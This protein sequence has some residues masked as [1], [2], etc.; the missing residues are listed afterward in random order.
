MP[1]DPQL[2]AALTEAVGRQPDAVPLRLHLAG[3]LLESG[4]EEQA[5]SHY[6]AVL[7]LEPE[8]TDALLGATKAAE[9]LGDAKG[10]ALYRT[11]LNMA[12]PQEPV[13]ALGPEADKEGAV[14][15]APPG[16]AWWDLE[17]SSV[18]MSDVGGMGEVKRRLEVSFLGPMRNPDVRAAYGKALRGGLL[19]FGPPGCGKTFIARALAGELDARFI[20]VGLAD[21]LDMWLGESEKRVKELFRA[22]REHSPCVVFLDELDALGQKR[23]QLRHLGAQR[24]VVNQLLS[25]LDGISGGNEGV[26]VLAA[27]NHPWDVDTALLRPG[28]LDRMVLVLPPDRDARIVILTSKLAGRPVDHLDLNAIAERTGGFSGA[29]LTYLCDTATELAMEEAIQSGSIRQITQQHM[30][31]AL[32]EIRPSTREWFETARNFALFSNQGGV[33]DDLI[34]YMKEQKLM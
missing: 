16:H 31:R 21:I 24:G 30:Q 19:L 4:A 6:R 27:T 22:A 14:D 11:R 15:T 26:Y 17:V 32:K 28:R 18:R 10:A 33:Y 8:N 1:A 25:E 29:D 2:L 7:Q 20:A 9:A 23:T 13:A 34:R 5:L 3:L 12:R